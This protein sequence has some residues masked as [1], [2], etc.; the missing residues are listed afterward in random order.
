MAPLR[1][2]VAGHGIHT[3]LRKDTLEVQGSLK[4]ICS[5]ILFSPALKSRK[6]QVVRQE[7]ARQVGCF[8][9]LTSDCRCPGDKR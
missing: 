8:I 9:S 4:S 1:S 6:E 5:N 2:E 3:A 7:G